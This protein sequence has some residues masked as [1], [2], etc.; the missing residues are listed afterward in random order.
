M[1]LSKSVAQRIE[2]RSK[3]GEVAVVVP[4][5]GKPSKVFS[6]EKYLKMRELPKKTKPRK[7]AA[8][9]QPDPFGVAGTKRNVLSSLS[10]SEI[11]D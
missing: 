7:S 6:L 3:Q 10:R 1:S 11:Y 2:K 8:K 4:R 9:A 5:H